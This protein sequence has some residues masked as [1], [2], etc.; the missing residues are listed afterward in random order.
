MA[1]KEHYAGNV[2]P[3]FALLGFLIAG[4]SHGYDLHQCFVAEAGQMNKL[5]TRALGEF[6]ATSELR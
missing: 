3:E 2:S 6:G 5:W 1:E 4:A